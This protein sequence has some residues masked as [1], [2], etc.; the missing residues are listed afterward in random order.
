MIPRRA[1]G[2]GGGEGQVAVGI[3]DLARGRNEVRD[4]GALAI[5]SA[6]ES[7]K[8][9]EALRDGIRVR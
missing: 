7:A 1:V 3:D 8:L 6:H 9:G 2:V 5:G 4:V